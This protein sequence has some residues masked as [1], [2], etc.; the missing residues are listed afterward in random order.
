MSFIQKDYDTID[1]KLQKKI[2]QG[3]IIPRPIAWITSTNNDGSTN[4]AP[5]S[6]F[7]MLSPT[8]L[9]VSIL[10]IKG[11]HK[12]TSRNV[13]NNQEAV[14]HIG[15]ITLL[16]ELD[17]SSKPLLEN[18]SEVKLTNLTLTNS[19]SVKT[20][21]IKEAKIR[22]EVVLEKH[23]ELNNYNNTNIEADL[24]IFRIKYAH[25]DETVFDDEKGYILHDKLRPIARLSGPSYAEI[26]EVKSFERKFL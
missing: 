20:K 17:L 11:K 5:F 2:T 18:E 24:L 19:K 7:S 16:E 15:D 13:L 26:V 9:S 23:V 6:Y 22:L 8:M 21:A 12:D 1:E 14:I 4:L 25:L 3:S 10:R